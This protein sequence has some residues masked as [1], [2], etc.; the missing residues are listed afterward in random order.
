VLIIEKEG[1]K[2]K[3]CNEKKKNPEFGHKKMNY[4]QELVKKIN[5][6][7]AIPSKI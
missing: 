2:Q 7:H 3:F 6:Y 1:T 4:G 5:K